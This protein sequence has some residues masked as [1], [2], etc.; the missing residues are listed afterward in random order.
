MQDAQ[1]EKHVKVFKKK[2]KKYES[3]YIYLKPLKNTMF[4]EPICS[5]ENGFYEGDQNRVVPNPVYC[6]GLY[7][8]MRQ[9]DLAKIKVW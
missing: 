1:Q 5:P 8:L 3:L 4:L 7:L 9:S 6:N 2:L